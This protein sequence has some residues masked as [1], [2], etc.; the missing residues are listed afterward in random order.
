MNKNNRIDIPWE[1]RSSIN[2]SANQLNADK[3]R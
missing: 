2:A 1:D 3:E